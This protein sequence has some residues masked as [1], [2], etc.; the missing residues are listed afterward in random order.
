[1]EGGILEGEVGEYDLVE[2][3]EYVDVLEKLG[4]DNE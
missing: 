4:R 2:E 1:M 3:G